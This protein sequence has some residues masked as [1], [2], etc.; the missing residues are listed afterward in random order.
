[1]DTAH[2]PLP[3][4]ALRAAKKLN[5]E[6]QCWRW[7]GSPIHKL[8]RGSGRWTPVNNPQWTPHRIYAV[9]RSKKEKPSWTPNQQQLKDVSS[10][11]KSIDAGK[12]P[13]CPPETSPTRGK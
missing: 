7:D 1:M 4:L 10:L 9:T 12:K 13:T 11:K 6:L 5:P 3:H 8:S 2:Q